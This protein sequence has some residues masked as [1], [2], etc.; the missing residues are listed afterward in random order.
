MNN[1][2]RTPH[3]IPCP[4]CNE[5]T[6]VKIYEDTVLVKFPLCCPKCGRETLID[7]VTL[8]KI[9]SELLTEPAFT[10][11]RLCFVVTFKLF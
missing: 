2:K 4:V 10:E 8:R 1:K 7:M 9:K 6:D 3:W 11:S 5:K